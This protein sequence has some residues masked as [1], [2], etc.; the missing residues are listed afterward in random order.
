MHSCTYNEN[1]HTYIPCVLLLIVRIPCH[2]LMYD[3]NYRKVYRQ[4]GG[5]CRVLRFHPLINLTNTI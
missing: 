1:E 5:V 4:A 2:R 3:A